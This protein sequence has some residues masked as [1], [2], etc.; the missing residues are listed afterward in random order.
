MLTHL[1][2]EGSFVAEYITLASSRVFI[3][4]KDP[5]LSLFSS[6]QKGF[7]TPYQ[8]PAFISD[9][10]G[11]DNIEPIDRAVYMSGAEFITLLGDTACKQTT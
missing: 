1:D 2:D 4:F 8:Q 7:Y 11:N 3:H 5:V 9:T 6:S 10:S